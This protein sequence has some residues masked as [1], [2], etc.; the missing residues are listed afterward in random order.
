MYFC[1]LKFNQKQIYK[2]KLNNRIYEKEN[3]QNCEFNKN[4]NQK[5][6]DSQPAQN[7]SLKLSIN[8][9]I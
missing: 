1:G 8:K 2:T 9:Y 5:L 4:R 3:C 7:N 6:E